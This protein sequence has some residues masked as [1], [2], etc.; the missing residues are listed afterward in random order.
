[1]YK[2]TKASF[3]V[4]ILLSI[5]LWCSYYK[6]EKSG[7]DASVSI[8]HNATAIPFRFNFSLSIYGNA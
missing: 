2:A 6:F 3:S 1:M 4:R 8:H 5:L 7:V